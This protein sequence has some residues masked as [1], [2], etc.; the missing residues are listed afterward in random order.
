VKT[1]HSTIIEFMHMAASVRVNGVAYKSLHNSQN[2]YQYL[3][4][5]HSTS[6]VTKLSVS[7][8]TQQHSVS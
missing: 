7:Y 5:K 2:S 6:D 8:Q 1:L 3:I 4:Y